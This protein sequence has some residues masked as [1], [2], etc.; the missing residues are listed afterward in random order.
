MFTAAMEPEVG[1]MFHLFF[2]LIW[3]VSRS[4]SPF[5]VRP[6]RGRVGDRMPVMGSILQEL[7]HSDK[8]ENQGQKI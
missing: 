7:D 8:L 4:R 5:P 3:I 2:A 1:V 6:R